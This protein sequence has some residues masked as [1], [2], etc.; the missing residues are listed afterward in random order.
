MKPLQL[1]YVPVGVA[2]FHLESA[3]AELVKSAALLKSL[4]EGFICPRDALL[5]LGHWLNI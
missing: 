3:R 1:I 4:D 5:S 2:T